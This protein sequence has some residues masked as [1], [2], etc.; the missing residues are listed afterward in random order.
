[1][2][3]FAKS[4]A[5]RTGALPLKSH[6]TGA[7]LVDFVYSAHV[8]EARPRVGMC[9]AQGSFRMPGLQLQIAVWICKRMLF[10]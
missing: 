4:C 3:R 9:R 1:M 5:E 6:G 7:A 8:H 2:R 10:R